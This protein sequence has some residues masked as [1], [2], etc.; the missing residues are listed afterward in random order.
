[1][2]IL[3]IKTSALGDCL[4]CF[5]ALHF[6]KKQEGNAKID[7]VVEKPFSDVLRAH[8][9][10]N[11]IITIDSKKWKKAPF[12]AQSVKEFFAFKKRLKSKAYDLIFDLQGNIKSGLITSL[13]KGK[14]KVGWTFSK[15]AEWPSSLFVTHRFAP[16]SNQSISSQYLELVQHYFSLPLA[17]VSSKFKLK[18]LPQEK[19]WLES[20]ISKDKGPKFM[21]CMGSNWENK[22]L[23]IFT[24]KAFL[25]KVDQ[26]YAPFF[27][28]VWGSEKE[29]KEAKELFKHFFKNSIVVPKMRLAVWQ[30]MMEKMQVIL[31]VDSSAL[32]L[33]STTS[34]PSFSFFGPSSKSVYLPA[35]EQHGGIQ[36][37]CPYKKTFKKRCPKL[38]T[39]L[40]GSC[41]KDVESR[42]LFQAFDRW[43]SKIL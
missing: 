17:P 34:R 39:C 30:N 42:L 3:I 1:M 28:F 22:K 9:F 37:R 20:L 31:C 26:K 4:Q 32:H 16:N 33:A 12:S 18:I 5:S 11:D 38:R 14:K 13:A 6:L 27:F 41:L 15:A 21:V 24:W 10:I 43:Y 2:K 25:E 8:P 36:G 19:E 35:G 7:W 23:S 40:T 29:K